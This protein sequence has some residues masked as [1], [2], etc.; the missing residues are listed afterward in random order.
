[1]RFLLFALLASTAIMFASCASEPEGTTIKGTITDAGGM[2]VFLDKTTL[3]NK[4]MVLGQMEADESGAFEFAY[5][6]G[7]DMGIYRLRLGSKRAYFVLSGDEHTITVNGDLKTL[8]K[9][10]F[11]ISGGQAAEDFV[12]AMRGISDRSMGVAE[13]Q[14]FMKDVDEPLVG[15]QVGVLTLGRGDFAAAH[16]AVSA[17]MKDVHPDADYTKEYAEYVARLQAQYAQKMARERIKVGM[18]A[19][20]ITLNNPEGQAY[21]LSELKGNV[22]LLDFWASWCGPCRKANPHVVEIYDKYKDK[23]FTVFSVS[24]DGIDARTKRRFPNE[25]AVAKNMVTQKDRWVKAIEKDQLAW[26]YHVSELAKWDT[27][28]AKMYGV[29]GIPK[30]F[31]I[32]REGNIAAVNPRYNLEEALLKV[33]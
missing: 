4:S 6:E 5:P 19:P 27:K 32:D 3:Q 12:G 8:D 31:L 2:K 26:E 24:L 1:M 33:L 11:E 20:D 25:E 7:L 14:K 22:V 30:T 28:A 15:A 29:T 10:A 13:I 17:R 9:Y 23:G 21:S 18:P 16:E